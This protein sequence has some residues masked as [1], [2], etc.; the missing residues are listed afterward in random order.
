M[1]TRQRAR[2]ASLG[3]VIFGCCVFEP[4]FIGDAHAV[5]GRPVTP[6]SYAGTARRTTR[7][8]TPGVGAPGPGVRRW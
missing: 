3:F 4:L 5:V 2:W 1:K 6:V 7:A 8:V